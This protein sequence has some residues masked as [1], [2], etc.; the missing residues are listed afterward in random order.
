MSNR[1]RPKLA[2]G[3]L[4]DSDELHSLGEDVE[5]LVR[6]VVGHGGEFLHSALAEL[7][8]GKIVNVV[9]TEQRVTLDLL[10]PP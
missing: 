10:C 4:T 8:L 1:S 2:T 7:G 6:D 9:Q 3:K 5:S